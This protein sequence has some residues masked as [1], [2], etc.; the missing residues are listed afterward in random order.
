MDIETL[1]PAIAAPPRAPPLSRAWQQD[2]LAR[3]YPPWVGLLAMAAFTLAFLGWLNETWL[4][5]WDS[6]IWLNR[7][8]EY[9][10]ILLFGLW[11]IV[12]EQN[13]YTRRRLI[14]LMS[15]VTGLWWLVPWLMPFFEPYAGY[16]WVQPVFPALH[17]P[18]TLTFMLVLLLVLLFGRRVICGFGC[19]CVG[20]RETVGFPF[21]HRT[22]RGPW[23]DRLR[24]IKWL[25]FIF[26]VGVLVV[27]Q[28]PPTGWTT[29]LVGLFGLLVALSYFGSFFLIPLTGNRFYCRSLCPFGATFG[30]LN[31]AGLYDLRMDSERCIDCGRCEQACDMG[32][33]V[34]REGKAHG[35]IQRLEDCMGCG[36]CV[37]SCPTDALQIRDLR[38][39]LRPQLRQDASHLLKRKGSEP[40]PPRI[41]IGERQRL[42]LQQIQQQ[43]ARCLDCGEP[44]CRQACPQQN[45]IPE[46]LMLAQQGA[47]NA[48]ADLIHR[49]NPLP[50]FCGQ[51]CPHQRLCEGACARQRQGVGAVAIGAIEHAVVEEAIASGW[52]PQNRPQQRHG[53]SAATVGAGPAALA[54]AE[55]L[56]R[57]GWQVT[58]YDRDLQIGGML[59]SGLPPFRFDKRALKRRQLMMERDGITFQLGEEITQ[60]RFEQLCQQHEVLFLG[61]GARSP[62]A[63]ALPGSNK[64]EVT[65]A[66]TFLAQ[67]NRGM[68]A[69]AL[70]GERVVVVGGGDSAI[71]CA[72]AAHRAG[73]H[74]VTVVYRGAL[75][76][77]RASIHERERATAEGIR[78]LY[79][80]HPLAIEGSEAVTAIRFRVEGNQQLIA[81][82]KVILAVGQQGSSPAWLHHYG[83]DLNA[84]LVVVDPQG[85]TGAS[86]IYA[87]GDCGHGADLI[88]RAAAAGQRAALAV[89]A[90]HRLTARIKQQLRPRARPRP[91]TQLQVIS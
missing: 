62:T 1:I 24:H 43:A 79:H 49:T 21:R 9:A 4:F 46:W 19:P 60:T 64:I 83:V 76:K 52:Q 51:L 74:S 70:A 7:Y 27:T 30:I 53:R 58:V 33:P 3:R 63:I 72:R 34:M 77:M 90:D 17:T 2:T 81:C 86:A 40:L 87:G 14:I 29:T 16:L 13:P 71:D 15:V 41:E 37:V 44:A 80:H 91:P 59:S 84:G 23:A 10:I 20:I 35:S 88:S 22:L 50:E 12:A 89:V 57:A 55:F 38:N 18:G 5:L 26:Y 75:E 78:F 66:L 68:A 47:I 32:I 39:L 82:D 48:A 67:F 6:P 54:F 42:T 85:R 25:F 56:N 73:A 61:L 28:F 69:S 36:R 11:R 45:R 31:H 65:D 8:T